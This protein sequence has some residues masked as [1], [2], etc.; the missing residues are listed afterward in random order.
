MWHKQESVAHIITRRD[1]ACGARVLLTEFIWKLAE[2]SVAASAPRVNKAVVGK[3][4]CMIA[5]T[6]YRDD[7]SVFHLFDQRRRTCHDCTKVRRAE[8]EGGKGRVVRAAAAIVTLFGRRRRSGRRRRRTFS[9]TYTCNW[10]TSSASTTTAATATTSTTTIRKG[11]RGGRGRRREP[12]LC[13][14]IVAPHPYFATFGHH[15]HV[16]SSAGNSATRSTHLQVA[17]ATNLHGL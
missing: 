4:E 9:A 17:K 7:V 13:R 11:R 5:A 10:R 16:T 1:A 15:G 3:R 2:T 12:K 8:D 14:A 6:S